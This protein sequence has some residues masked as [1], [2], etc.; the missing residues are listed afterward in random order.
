MIST[1]QPG[2]Q[3][4][5]VIHDADDAATRDDRAYL[6]VVEVAPVAVSSA[7]SRVGDDGRYRWRVG[8][9]GREEP[10]TRYVREVDE[11]AMLVQQLDGVLGERGEMVAVPAR[12]RGAAAAE[13]R[14]V[15]V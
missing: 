2:A 14:R 13:G 1:T 7:H 10:V 15:Q 12:E 8:V 11:H 4:G 5:H 6:V 3:I 9:D